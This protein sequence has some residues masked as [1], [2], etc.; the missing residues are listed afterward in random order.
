MEGNFDLWK[1]WIR[2]VKWIELSKSKLHT[3][4][5][6]LNMIKGEEGVT[7]TICNIEDTIVFIDV[8]I[9]LLIKVELG[10]V[11]A[12]YHREDND[13]NLVRVSIRHIL[14]NGYV[15]STSCI[16]L[17]LTLE[18]NERYKADIHA[19][20]IL[21]QGGQANTVD[22]DVDETMFMA[23]LS[24]ANPIYNETGPSYD[25]NI[26]SEVQD[27]D[28]YLNSVDE[29][30]EVHEM[31]NDVQQN[32]V[33]DS[34]VEY[35]SDSNIIPY[36]QLSNVSANKQNKVVNESLIAELAR[37]KKQV[38]IYENRASAMQVQSAL[39][40]GHKLVKTNHVPAVVHDSEDTLD[41]A[42]IT[43]KRMLEKVKSPLCVE[44]KV[45]IAP[46]DYSKENYLATFTLQRHLTPRTDILDLRHFK[47]D[48][49]TNFKNDEWERGFEQ[50]K[51]CY[52]T[53][54]IPF[55]KTLK[56]H[57]EGI[58]TALVKEVK[59][60]KEIFE[61]MEAE[62]EKLFVVNAVNTVSRFSEMHDAHTVEQVRCLE[63]EAEISKL[64]HK[65]KKDDHSVMIKH[66]SNLEIDHLNLQLKYQNL[67]E[68]FGNNKSQTS[69]D[70]P[71]FD[72]F[73]EINKM[74]E[75]L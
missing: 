29:Y 1:A 18:E 39:Y 72:S 47:N 56:E 65:I 7:K 52:L 25:T 51:E 37:Y 20:N 22:D 67:K 11:L 15:I 75:Q 4:V 62:V 48:P 46:P 44:K 31:N 17:D 57:F 16:V 70:T 42:G 8:T 55:F 49:E 14:R 3:L 64:K 5:P 27:H 35:T 26:L 10:L 13:E 53:E 43:R 23:N 69:Q 33:V 21:L 40:N 74:K 50:T 45:K 60:M 24:L 59:E 28:N 9:L 32:Y 41:L 34:N 36:D 61:Q 12:M 58:Q 19:R 54:V 66:F 73:F 68:R 71:E 38:T 6:Y 2:R 63:L 30:Q